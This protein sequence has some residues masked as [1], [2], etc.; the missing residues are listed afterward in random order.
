MVVSVIDPVGDYAGL[1]EALFDFAAIRKL[2]AES[3]RI[4][5]DAMHAV[6]GPY[7]REI[8]VNRLGRQPIA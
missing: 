3:F 6:T 2:L 1:M 8:F 5:F 4:R 7:A